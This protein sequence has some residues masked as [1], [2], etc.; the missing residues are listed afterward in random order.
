MKSVSNECEA[1]CCSIGGSISSHSVKFPGIVSALEGKTVEITDAN[2]TE[3]E[4]LWGEFGF[5]QLSENFSKFF[6][7]SK[8]IYFITKWTFQSIYRSR[9]FL[10]MAEHKSLL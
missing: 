6:E 7:G 3:L 1:E 9:S 10:W 5:K 8:S 4:P 2:I